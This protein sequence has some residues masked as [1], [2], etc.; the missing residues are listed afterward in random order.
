MSPCDLREVSV[1]SARLALCC[2]QLNLANKQFLDSDSY[3][4]FGKFKQI[5]AL[6]SYDGDGKDDAS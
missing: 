3:F 5:V 2:K 6:P 1:K 4:P